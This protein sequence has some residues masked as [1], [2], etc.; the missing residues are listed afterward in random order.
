[1]V[2]PGGLWQSSQITLAVSGEMPAYAGGQ[3]TAVPLN[4]HSV[5]KDTPQHEGND[6]YIQG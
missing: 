1:M 3:F 5:K 6:P 2:Y 4:W